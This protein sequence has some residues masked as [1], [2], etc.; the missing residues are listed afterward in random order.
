VRG[1]ERYG[2]VTTVDLGRQ[3][4]D[5]R[6]LFKEVV[7][8]RPRKPASL[9]QSLN[10]HLSVYA[11]AAGAAEVGVLALGQPAEAKIVY[12]PTHVKFGPNATIQIDINHDGIFDYQLRAYDQAQSER[13]ALLLEPAPKN[14]IYG[15]ANR[16]AYASALTHGASVGPTGQFMR[17]NFVLMAFGVESGTHSSS[18]FVGQWAGEPGDRTVKNH[19]LGFRFR[20]KGQIHYGWARLT[21]TSALYPT[22]IISTLTGYAYE[23][24]PNKAIITGKTKGSDDDSVEQPTPSALAAPTPEPATLGALAL[25]APGLSIWRREEPA[26]AAR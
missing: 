13:A 23:T 19:Y 3:I 12:T 21:V 15:F 5:N 1:F 18:A 4:T 22:G 9:S 10:R 26:D 24:I 7:M 16:M 2:L 20:I 6:V 17:K 8:K 25:G 14:D 11:L